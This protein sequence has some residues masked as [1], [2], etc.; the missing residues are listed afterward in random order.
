MYIHMI[1]KYLG[2]ELLSQL[3]LSVNSF[4][5]RRACLTKS[6]CY[7]NYKKKGA[8]NCNYFSAWPNLS[9]VDNTRV[10]YAIVK[11]HWPLI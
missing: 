5:Y 8:T 6:N 9:N 11:P 4:C 7:N 10:N 3:Q 2:I 1:F